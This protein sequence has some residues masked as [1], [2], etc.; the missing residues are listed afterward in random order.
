[1]SRV[2]SQ[3]LLMGQSL[4]F[5]VKT[6]EGISSKFALA[7]SW[8]YATT[9][10]GAPSSTRLVVASIV[11]ESGATPVNMI[12]CTIGGIAATFITNN[13]TLPSFGGSEGAAL[14]YVVI[15]TGTT[16]NVVPT[17]DGVGALG[18]VGVYTLNNLL[19]PTPIDTF[20]MALAST[21]PNSFYNLTMNAQIGGV[22]ISGSCFAAA[23]T[24]YS[25][26]GIT[27]DAGFVFNTD[28]YN[29][30]ASANIAASNTAY[31]MSMA[32]TGGAASA[33]SPCF[34]FL[35]WR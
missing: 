34:C 20:N 27:Q 16:V 28:F 6:F 12:S 18:F 19:S 22:I 4:L 2:I 17:F 3:A 26:S 15:P 33:F 5:V 1:M 8:T 32:I 23:S 21:I 35:S 30:T 9:L 29:F 25:S 14:A 10:S 24:G 31:P 13:Q 7:N 11:W